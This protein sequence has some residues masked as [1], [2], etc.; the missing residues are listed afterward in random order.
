MIDPGKM[1][2]TQDGMLGIRDAASFLGLPRSTLY[3]LMNDGR[4]AWAKVGR[5]RLIPK[6]ALIAFA[7]SALAA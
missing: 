3:T 6:R 1:D 4:L 5:R 2:L 7:A